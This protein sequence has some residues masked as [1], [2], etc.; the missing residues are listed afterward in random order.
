MSVA[1]EKTKTKPTLNW[2]QFLGRNGENIIFPALGFF[3]LIILW[4]ILAKLTEGKISELPNPSRTFEDSLPY[5][6]NFFSQTQ[7]DEGIFFLTLYSLVRVAFGFVIAM[8][9]A[10]PLG[11]LIGTSRQAAKMMNPLI[12]LGKP[13]SPL[14]WLPVGIVLFTALLEGAPRNIA[15]NAPAI[16]VIVVTSLWPTLINTALGVKSIPK[17]YWNV[18]KVLKLSKPQVV[19]EIMI[20]STLPYI[21]T[22]MR[23]SLGIA[24]LVIVA[25]EM[26]TGATGIGFFVWDTYNTGEISLVILSLFVIGIVGL[27]L[28]Q[29]VAVVERFVVGKAQLQN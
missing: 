2:T 26:L 5:L 27:L 8:A 7:G 9:I 1:T 11:F 16:F 10:I 29:L 14:A 22:G 12:Q 3:A 23:L 13:I 20:P 4:S 15:Q 18:S 17:D 28:D 6:Q 24:W 19:T 21:F 25:A